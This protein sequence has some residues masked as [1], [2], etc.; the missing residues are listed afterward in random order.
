M[1]AGKFQLKKGSTGKFHF[2][3]VATNGQVIATSES[4][5]TKASALKGIE[6]VRKNAPEAKL[7]DQT[8]S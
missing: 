3:L 5:E 2:N 8:G 7:D 4:Y 1:M 6:S